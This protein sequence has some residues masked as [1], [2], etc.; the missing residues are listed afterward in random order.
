MRTLS[1][2]I[3]DKGVP[4]AGTAKPKRVYDA[5]KGGF[6]NEQ[7]LSE[8]DVPLWTLTVGVPEGVLIQPLKVVV[9]SPVK[10]GVE[11]GEKIRFESW[12]IYI[13]GDSLALRCEGISRADDEFSLDFQET[14]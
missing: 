12:E 6:T 8:L 4:V 14:K 1:K 2:N 7:E 10:P 5:K 13:A 11:I 3:F 9:E